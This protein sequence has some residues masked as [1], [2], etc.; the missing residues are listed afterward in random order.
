MDQLQVDDSCRILNNKT[1]AHTNREQSDH[2]I[3]SDA[4]S[5]SS[6]SLQCAT[7][8]SLSPYSWPKLLD[9]TFDHELL[10]RD[11]ENVAY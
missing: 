6:L 1:H 3:L 4:Q 7:N 10:I 9:A 8:T 11:D 2:V 5:R